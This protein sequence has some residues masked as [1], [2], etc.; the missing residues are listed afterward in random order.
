[1]PHIGILTLSWL[2]LINLIAFIAIWR[3]KRRAEKG[4]WRISE[5]TLYTF[6]A[7][8]GVWGM[9]YG[10]RTF[11]HK[12][13]KLSFLAISSL[14]VLLNLGYYYGTWTLWRSLTQQ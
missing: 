3:D 14:L 2:A 12:T 1:M 9:L 8:G 6:G 7:L 5:K 10:M 4:Q 11:R 13:R